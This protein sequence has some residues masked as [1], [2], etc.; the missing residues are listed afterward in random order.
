MIDSCSQLLHD[1]RLQRQPLAELPPTARPSTQQDAYQCQDQVVERLLA[2][3]GGHIIGYK[4]A[5][6][7]M[8]AQRL[9]NMPEPFYGRLLSSFCYDSPAHV[10]A[11]DFFMRIIESEFAFRFARDLPPGPRPLERDEIADALEGVL[12]GIEIVDSRFTSWTTVGA[13]SLIADN[14][15]HGAWVKGALIRDW[16]N[17]DLAAQAVELSV[18]GQV[19]QRGSGAAVLGHPLTALQ[20]LVHRLHAQGIGFQAGQYVTT[21]VTTDIYDAQPGD[22]LIADFGPVGRIELAFD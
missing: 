1:A 6:T 2:Q 9:L 21:G 7:N 8:I 17:L 12:P 4:I 18:N 3:Y 19:V 16:K 15:C 13:P 10:P 5:C 14:A 22:R 11:G 20:W